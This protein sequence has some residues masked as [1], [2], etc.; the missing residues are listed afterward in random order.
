MRN[1]T[2]KLVFFLICVALYFKSAAQEVDTTKAP[3]KRRFFFYPNEKAV[4]MERKQLNLAPNPAKDFVEIRMD[5]PSR[6]P[7]KLEIFDLSG[8]RLLLREWK[9]EKIDL[10]PFSSGLYILKLSGD[11]ES[12]SGKL[13]IKK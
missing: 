2:L 10:N 12:Y 13:L 4:Q 8:T 5:N 6:L 9:G 11:R 1:T 7:F 3:A